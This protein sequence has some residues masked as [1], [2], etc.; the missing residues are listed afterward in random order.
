MTTDRGSQRVQGAARG[1]YILEASFAIFGVAAFVLGAADIIRIFHARTAVRQ[2]VTDGLR[3]LYPTAERCAVSEPGNAN[4]NAPLFSSFVQSV[5]GFEYPRSS[6]TLTSGW[7]DEPL[8]V[9]TRIQKKL[10]SVDVLY[11][12]DAYQ[13]HDVLFPVD[14][15]AMYLLQT[16]D[17]PIVDLHPDTGLSPQIRVL[18]AR[19]RD[20]VT[21]GELAGEPPGHQAVS[22]SRV[23]GTTNSNARQL[24]GQV[25]FSVDDAWPARASDLARIA[26]L[27]AS[28][29]FQGKIPCFQ[30]AWKQEQNGPVIEWPSTT[31]PAACS[32]QGQSTELF[33]GNDLLVPIMMRIGGDR[34]STASDSRGTVSAEMEFERGGRR[35]TYSLGGRAFQA[36]STNSSFVIR[37]VGRGFDADANYFSVCKD[38]ALYTECEQYAALPLVPQGSRVTIRFYL[39]RTAGTGSVGWAGDWLQLFYPQYRLGQEKRSCGR[40]L[41]P[42][43][44]GES[45]APMRSLLAHTDISVG[46][47]SKPVVGASHRCLV[48]TP[49]GGHQSEEA[50]LE[51]L[52]QEF[53][54]GKRAVAPTQ[55][56]AVNGQMRGA[57][58][59]ERKSNITCTDVGVSDY[60]GCQKPPQYSEPELVSKCSISNFRPGRDTVTNLGWRDTEL[61]DQ[62]QRAACSDQPF[63]ECAERYLRSAGSQFLSDAA[64]VVCQHAIPQTGPEL[65]SG[66]VYDLVAGPTCANVVE[67]LKAQYRKKYPEVPAQVSVESSVEAL[68]PDSAAAP[69]ANPCQ[70]YSIGGTQE[71]QCASGVPY[72]TAQQCCA[73]RGGT[74]RI[75]NVREGS[76]SGS[77][78]VWSGRIALAVLRA[79]E[80]VR[81]A[82]PRVQSVGSA[83]CAPDA[84]RCLRIQ[85]ASL[86]NATRVQLS[87]SMQVPLAL[88]SW[89]GFSNLS[90]VEYSETRTLESALVGNVGL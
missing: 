4:F 79:E 52:R 29:G 57:C 32:Y 67:E 86:D 50:A 77:D 48:D 70:R 51:A 23:K 82:Y 33:D 56:V 12:R 8:R 26:S 7:F 24:L 38:Q 31:P 63:P 10:A 83:P 3:C 58:A 90:T 75:E 61:P 20:R 87:A 34:Y 40:S 9:A 85:G 1:W 66:A 54:S 22:L 65:R 39:Q 76:S 81:T 88:F 16:R 74:C 47:A 53:T 41:A 78:A 64:A 43:V 62:E 71:V 11:G 30:G 45:V 55:F 15:H 17:M 2:G 28:F 21:G 49:A 18:R 19:F 69:P 46:L 68:P 72:H 36:N 73:E 42:H 37:G 44:C 84:K 6:Y 60:R 80:T 25:E 5:E 59:P 14:A 35:R 89:L 13:S 27:R